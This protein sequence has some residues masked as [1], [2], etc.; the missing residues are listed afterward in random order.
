[1]PRASEGDRI[2]WKP[3]C[4]DQADKFRVSQ[5]SRTI[6]GSAV[7][8]SMRALGIYRTP[9]ALLRHLDWKSL[10][11]LR[12]T[13]LPEY[14]ST[15]VGY[16]D[17]RSHTCMRDTWGTWGIGGSRGSSA[18]RLRKARG[19]PQIPQSPPTPNSQSEPQGN[20]WGFDPSRFSF[21]RGGP[22]T[23]TGKAPR[24]LDPRF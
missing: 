2:P 14:T 1:M 10:L 17:G 20:C 16:T 19:E 13:Q 24:R 22:T 4:H 3:W 7:C 9:D 6:A 8:K 11:R 21:L 12:E 15:C 5:H 23:D 18:R